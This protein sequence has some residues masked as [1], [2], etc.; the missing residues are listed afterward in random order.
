M[1][2]ATVPQESQGFA[3]QV[4]T[5][6]LYQPGN[7]P[8]P[9]AAY[10]QPMP[11]DV[12][13]GKVRGTGVC[14]LLFILTFGIYGLVWYFQ[15]HDE[16]KRHRGDGLGGGIALVIAFFLGI[17]MPFLTADEV[18]RLYERHGQ[19]KPVSALTGLWSFPGSILL[20][21]PIVWFVKT[22]GALNAYWRSLGVQ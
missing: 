3:A 20:V 13:L 10:G 4:P 19:A 17:V 16:M 21:G 11:Y 18:G 2:D 14:M 1:D 9:H 5:H 15:V 8:A 6:P 12:A 7:V 22:N